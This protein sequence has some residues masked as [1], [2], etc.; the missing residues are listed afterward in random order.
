MRKEKTLQNVLW[1]FALFGLSHATF[2]LEERYSWN[3][4]DFVFPT[5]T[6]KGLLFNENLVELHFGQS[7]MF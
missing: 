2:K 4:M 6:M 7:Q 1:C 5:R 3:Q